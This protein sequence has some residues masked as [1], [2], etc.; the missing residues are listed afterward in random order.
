MKRYNAGLVEEYNVHFDAI[1]ERLRRIRST[2]TYPPKNTIG[3]MH[4]RRLL[5]EGEGGQSKSE[6][7]R[8][9]G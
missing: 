1:Y 5:W 8:E 7:E 2:R 6:T 9:V 3:G 4:K